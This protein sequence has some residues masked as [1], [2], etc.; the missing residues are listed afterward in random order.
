MADRVAVDAAHLRNLSRQFRASADE[1]QARVRQFRAQ[2]ETTSGA[3][4]ETPNAAAAEREYRQTVE[5]TLEKLGKMHRDLI[6]NA[7]ALAKQAKDYED[8]E[9]ENAALVTN[10]FRPGS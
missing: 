2:A 3:Y 4:G 8:T 10:T 5:Q 6:Q 9:A 1:L 7:D